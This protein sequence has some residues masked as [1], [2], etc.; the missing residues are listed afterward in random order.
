MMMITSVFA[1]VIVLLMVC[2]QGLWLPLSRCLDGDIRSLGVSTLPGI[3][4]V[5]LVHMAPVTG[6]SSHLQRR[7]LIKSGFH[8]DGTSLALRMSLLESRSDITTIH[9]VSA[10]LHIWDEGRAVTSH[11]HGFPGVK[12]MS[13]HC[14]T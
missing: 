2:N 9:R 6:F 14:L 1:F 12:T 3:A 7:H 10:T 13:H 8:P 4:P 11:G 5:H